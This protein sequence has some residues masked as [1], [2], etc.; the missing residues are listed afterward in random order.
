MTAAPTTGPDATTEQA[1]LD[2]DGSDPGWRELFVVPPAEG[3]PYP[4]AA[5]LVGNS[6]GLQPVAT[7]ADILADL[8]SWGR[9][10]V[11]GFF[12]G[13]RPWQSYPQRFAASM[14]GLI[15]AGPAETVI[16]NSLTV[17]LHLM[18]ASF[19]RPRGERV[20]IVVEDNTFP[21]DSYAV[22]SQA[23]W[24]GLDPDDAVV[25]LRPRPG[26]HHLRT[27]DVVDLLRRE[28]P[29]VAL[30]LLGAVNYHSGQLMDIPAITRATREAGAVSGWDL[31]HAAGNIPLQLH[32]WDVDFAVWC[33]YKYL[34]SGPGAPGGAFVH[35]RH[36]DDPAMPRLEGWWGTDAA[37]RF[38]MD[39]IPQPPPTADA[40]QVSTPS[41][42]GLS[43]MRAALDLFETVGMTTLRERSI[44]LTGY[45]ER[46]L[47]DIAA[48][49]PLTVITPRDPQQRGCQLSVRIDQGDAGEVA[50]RLRHEHGVITDFREPDIVRAAPVPL[51]STYHDCWRFADALT[52]LLP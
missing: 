10:G 44:R 7:R 34:N 50:R 46:V 45:L 48:S 24:H 47:D 1:A 12:D 41:A 39:A 38:R 29:T 43:P 3:G 32:D 37:V 31:A 2:A 22:R 4:Q 21:S 15:G 35:E 49:R 18:M 28:G 16:M 9:F 42:L 30:V 13:E 20:R 52:R 8:D 17:N 6:L 23:R 26:E 36:V 11:E 25:R 5:Y 51:Y 19:Y 27:D 14:A 33:M 40:W